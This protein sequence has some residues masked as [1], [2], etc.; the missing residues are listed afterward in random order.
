MRRGDGTLNEGPRTMRTMV[1]LL[2]IT[3]IMVVTIQWTAANPNLASASAATEQV[4]TSAF[5]EPISTA[6]I[7]GISI[8]MLLWK[9]ARKSGWA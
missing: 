5:P 4:Q 7:I 8:A 9:V 6:I 2:L 3:S 1:F